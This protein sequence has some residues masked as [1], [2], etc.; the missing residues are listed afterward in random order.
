MATLTAAA[1]GSH[2]QGA[3]IALMPTVDDAQLL[4][5]VGGEAVV[6]LHLTL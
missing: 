6:D 1:D 3:M 2:L 4:G 5:I